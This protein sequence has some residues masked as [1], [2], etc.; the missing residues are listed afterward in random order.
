M[1]TLRLR[2]TRRSVHKCDHQIDIRE[3]VPLITIPTLVYFS[4]DLGHT[5]VEQSRDLAARIPD[6]RLIEVPGKLFYQPEG[7][8]NWTSMPLH[9]RTYRP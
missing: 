4:G 9:R 6:A 2:P 7:I 8:H 1:W 5:N 3:L